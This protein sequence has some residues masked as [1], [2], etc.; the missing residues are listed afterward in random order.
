M[1]IKL[2]L[3]R[4]YVVYSYMKKREKMKDSKVKHF[5]PMALR[6]KFG[7]GSRTNSSPFSSFWADT[8]WDTR[9]TDFIDEDEPVKRGV[10]HVAL[11]SYRRAISN[12][13]TIVTNRS[14]IPVTFQSNDNSYTD[15]KKVV[16]GSKVDE[17]N[18]DPVVGLALHEGSHIKL[19]DFDFLRNLENQIP[20]E[21]FLR[22]EKVGFVKWDVI[23]HLKNLLNYVEDRRID[24]YVFSSSP[25]YKGYYHSMYDKYFHSKVIDKALLTDSHTSLDWDSYIMRILNLTNKNRRLDVLPEL[26][27]IYKTVFGGGRVKNLN[28]TEEAFVVAGEVYDII[29]N[30]LLDV[31]LDKDGKPVDSSEG[32]DSSG[33][34]SGEGSETSGGNGTT[35]SDE[36]FEDFLES[37]ENSDGSGSSEGGGNSI[38][39]PSTSDSNHSATGTDTKGK[40]I[41]LSDRQTKQLMKK[42]KVC[43]A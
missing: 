11:A 16:I 32:M 5:N 27:K 9:R 31:E 6:E 25:G 4:F 24:N 10:D 36:E 23:T 28:S 42:R 41:E 17:K 22:G 29:L 40:T 7:I 14:D 8:S 1:K 26:D 3:Y 38:E 30:N 39:I 19:S 13:V 33:E 35:L 18:F 37:M 34:G 12:F 21:V 2:D 20:Q 15:G 43:T